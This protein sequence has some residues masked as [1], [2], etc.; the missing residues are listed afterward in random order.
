MRLG[1]WVREAGRMA[2]ADIAAHPMRTALS[3][4]S[5]ALA[6]GI[7]VVLVAA[8]NGLRMVVGSVLQS[9]GEGQVSLAT[10]RTTGIGGQRRAGRQVQLRHDAVEAVGPELASFSSV[11]PFYNL[12]GGGASSRRYSIPWSPGR[13]VGF[14]YLSARGVPVLEGRWFTREE[15]EAGAWVAVLNQGL[16]RVLFPEGPALGEWIEWR[17]RRMEVVGVIRDEAAFPYIFLLPY[18]AARQIRDGRYISGVVARPKDSVQWDQAVGEL[19]RALAGLGGFDPG[20]EQALEIEDNREFSSRVRTGL[21]ALRLLVATIGGVSLLLGALGVAN[22]LVISVTERTRE[23][24]LRK[25]LGA[26]SA[27]I[28]L[29]VLS[30]ALLIV[31]LGGVVGAVLGGVACGAL[32][33]VPISP[34]YAADVRF[35]PHVALVSFA[36][37]TVV[38]IVAGTL[39]ARRASSLVAAEALRWE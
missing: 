4:A 24:G 5:F 18:R 19:R 22:M 6:L 20:D 28:F 37:L 36:A 29:Q 8:G 32:A 27:D 38:G 34:Q 3:T 35:D 11:A 25:A 7:T 14:E 9:L 23:I 33:Q 17:G 26:T 10:G 16:R 12:F 21:A 39:P 15:D 1:N 2:V 31:F 13:A 30:E